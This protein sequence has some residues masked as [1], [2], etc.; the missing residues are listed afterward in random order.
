MANEFNEHIYR[1]AAQEHI[2][3]AEKLFQSEHYVLGYYI[4]GTAVECIFRAYRFRNDP[5]FESRHDLRKLSV[6]S[7]FL[8]NLPPDLYDEIFAATSEVATRWS[9]DH[10]YRSIDALRSFL[11]KAG[12]NRLNGSATIR[13][14]VVEYNANAILE[15]ATFIVTVGLR[16]W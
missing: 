16:Q 14:S 13:G 1:R 5:K 10:R 2:L 7:G 4:A 3:A 12:L 6:E 8:N 9:N 11:N 15:A